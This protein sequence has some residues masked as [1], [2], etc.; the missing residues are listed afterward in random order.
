MS[1]EAATNRHSQSVPEQF[2]D[3]CLDALC[4]LHNNFL[5]IFFVLG[6]YVVY[7][8]DHEIANPTLQLFDLLF[9]S[10]CLL[11]KTIS[12]IVLQPSQAEFNELRIFE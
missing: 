6:S 12:S 11:I 7:D 5:A 8:D 2:F 3:I 9:N 1:S 4:G 10:R